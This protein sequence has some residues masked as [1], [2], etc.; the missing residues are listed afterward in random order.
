MEAVINGLNVAYDVSER[1]PWWKR[2]TVAVI[3]TVLLAVV[4]LCAL[5]LW[6]FGGRLG[7]YLAAK[8]GYGDAFDAVW[9]VLRFLFVP[10]FLLLVF[11]IIYRYAPNTRAQGWQALMP[12][13]LV[14]TV[15]WLAAT[16]LF[17]LYLLWFDS[18]TKTYGS[19]GAVIVL[20]MWLYVSGAA[21]LVGGEVNSEIRKAAAEAGVEEAK[22]PI[23]APPS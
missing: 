12:G 21:M 10:L 1:R 9:F 6:L 3:L 15:A 18:Y 22:Q 23:E 16:A 8:F 14:G 11:T 7:S 20:M 13:A 19:L 2:R 17:R 4:S 5:A